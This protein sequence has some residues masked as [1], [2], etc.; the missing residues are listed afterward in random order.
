MKDSAEF[1]AQV[2]VFI[3]SFQLPSRVSPVNTSAS[4]YATS[5]VDVLDCVCV[6]VRV[7]ACACLLT[8]TRGWVA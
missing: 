3:N 6:R 1:S 4:F 2:R 8:M 7:S 5:A